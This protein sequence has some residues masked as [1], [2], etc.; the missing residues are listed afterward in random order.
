MTKLDRYG[1]AGLSFI[2]AIFVVAKLYLLFSGISSGHVCAVIA[3]TAFVFMGILG[4]RFHTPYARRIVLAL[5]ACW[6]GDVLGIWNF[7]HGLAAFFAAHLVLLTA[8]WAQGLV[9]RKFFRF[10]GPVLATNLAVL[11]W[12]F[13]HVPISEYAPVTCYLSAISLMLLFAF[14]AAQA[15]GGSIALMGA[16]IFF[17][18]DVFV[19][20]W[21]YVEPS[22]VNALFCYPLYYAACMLF[23]LSAWWNTQKLFPDKY[24]ES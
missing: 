10:L 20:R 6:M 5:I 22:A 9:W 1:M 19:A 2:M 12:L 4:G 15:P 3:S 8:F 18:S 16:V 17:I 23:A 7:F 21:K 14:A 11:F 24:K 13:P